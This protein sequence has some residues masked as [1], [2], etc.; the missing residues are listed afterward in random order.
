M[1][2]FFLIY[3]ACFGCKAD[4]DT[5]LRRSLP[6]VYVRVINHE[7]AIGRDT[8][9]VSLL[10]DHTRTYS[11]VKKAGF[12]QLVEGRAVSHKST[13]ERFTAI[14]DEATGSL[15]DHHKMKTFTPVSA[16]GLLL[17][18]SVSYKKVEQ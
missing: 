1:R 8:L 3:L 16:Q 5:I 4:P 13:T 2:Y 18:G 10:D 12:M 17:S 9:V 11:V 15:N 7:F 14:L 6:G